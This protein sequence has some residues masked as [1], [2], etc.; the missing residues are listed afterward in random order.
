MWKTI[1][2]F[3]DL[4][5]EQARES[6]DGFN[7]LSAEWKRKGYAG[8]C[9]LEHPHEVTLQSVLDDYIESRLRAKAKNPEK[10]IK[11][12]RWQFERYVPTAWKNRGLGSIQREQ[13]RE[14][15]AKVGKDHGHYSANRIVGLLRT[16]FNW[17]IKNETWD[18]KNPAKGIDRFH[19][20]KRT[21]FTQ[22]D[23]LPKLFKALQS[24]MNLDLRDFVLLALTTG[25]RR[26]NVLAM[27]WE[28]LDLVTGLWSIPD[29]KN[30][31]PYT[32]P[33]IRE[34][35]GLL[36]VRRRRIAGDWVFPSRSKSGHV[37]DVKK[38]WKRFLVRAKISGLRVHDLRRTLGSWQA[39]AG[40]SLPIIGKTLGHLSGDATAVY[41]RL[42]L[43][44]V[45]A[46]I[47]L[48]TSA[49]FTAGKTTR[50]K[51]LEAPHE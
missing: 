28:Q 6:A 48:A 49:M 26:S 27:R 12:T 29:P 32:V 36:K 4:S 31:V 30:R 20:V 45:R 47:E 11:H 8:A 17:A 38:A 43:D 13:V 40:V 44:P 18:G 3:P 25:A 22:P 2:P 50:Q 23:E 41:A 14:L 21:R 42:H 10:A 35:V 9:P 15:H 5:I 46:A 37:M 16:L 34:A 24:E 19:E 7:T 1:G 51:L 39:G 33:L